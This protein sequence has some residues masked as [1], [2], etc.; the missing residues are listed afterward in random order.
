[1]SV[2]DRQRIAQRISLLLHQEL[3]QGI[4]IKRMVT[5]ELYARDVLLVCDALRGSDLAELSRL[6]RLAAEREA[7]DEASGHSS[8]PPAW[9]D[10]RPSQP[11]SRSSIWPSSW[12]KPSRPGKPGKPG[13]K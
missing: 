12:F 13:A 6:Y 7:E 11:S 1:M 3:G 9:S 5:S 8:I 10:S 4:D 2:I